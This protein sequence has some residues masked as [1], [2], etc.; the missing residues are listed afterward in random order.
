MEIHGECQVD[1]KKVQNLTQGAS[2][3]HAGKLNA[4][5]KNG[6]SKRTP[7]S[8]LQKQGEMV[9]VVVHLMG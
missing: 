1:G 6:F 8:N 7:S 5:V 3:D 2:K 9:Q 4:Y